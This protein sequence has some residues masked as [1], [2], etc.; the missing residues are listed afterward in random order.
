[1][2]SDTAGTRL[3]A[4]TGLRFFAALAVVLYHETSPHF[5]GAP[6]WLERYLSSGY[7]SVSL[8]FVLSGYILAYNYL[9]AGRR[10]ALHA[11]QFWSA[12]VARIY[13]VYALG[14]VLGLP[15][16]VNKLLVQGGAPGSMAAEGLGVVAAA[17][18]LLQ[19]WIPGTACRLNCPGWSLSVEAFFYLVF[20]VLGLLLARIPARR[21]PAALV[22]AWGASVGLLAGVRVAAVRGAAAAGIALGAGWWDPV[23]SFPLLR[24]GEFTFGILLGLLFLARRERAADGARWVAPLAPA[25]LVGIAALLPLEL[26]EPLGVARQQL[27]V[28]LFGLLV[29]GLAHGRGIVARALSLPAV[30]LLGE[31]SYA[32]YIL[33]VPIHS[34]M[35][36]VDKIAGL[37]VHDTPLWF[38][39]YLATAVAASLA[40]YRWVEVPSRDRV[41]S[42]LTRRFGA[43]ARGEREAGPRTGHAEPASELVAERASA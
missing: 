34:L 6:A 12:R 42:Y 10:A 13:P 41:R 11:P 3:D 32:L 16:F 31:A 8:F 27:L 26:P 19:A 23:A 4:L 9:P 14:L 24:L 30:V 21:L 15:F 7:V 17:T 25:A 36:A 22:L 20:P 33:H 18:S 40:A 29:F 2:R 39:A 28:P 37:G 38:P 43:G 5:D 1:M 35:G